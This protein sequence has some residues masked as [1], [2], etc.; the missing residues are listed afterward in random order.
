MPFNLPLPQGLKAS[1][2]KVKIY[3]NE[4]VEPPHVT[5]IR[6]AE[7]WR[8][9]LRTRRFLDSRPPPRDVPEQ[10]LELLDENWHHLCAEWD[11]MFPDNPVQGDNDDSRDR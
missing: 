1:G 7:S 6:R 4:T 11:G 2:W 9:C 3:D 5:V 8:W 10:I